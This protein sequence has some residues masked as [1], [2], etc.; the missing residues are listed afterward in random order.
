MRCGGRRDRCGDGTAGDP[1]PQPVRAN[2]FPPP[3]V[4]AARGMLSAGGV[5]LRRVM[6]RQ[7]V[8]R[9]FGPTRP[10]VLL[11]GALAGRWPVL[12]CAHSPL[13]AGGP[14]WA[15]C[16]GSCVSR[17]AGAAAVGSAGVGWDFNQRPTVE[18]C[19]PSRAAIS[20]LLSDGCERSRRASLSDPRSS[21]RLPGAGRTRPRADTGD[22]VLALADGTAAGW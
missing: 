6:H 15:S 3:P 10:L 22:S 18:G 11:I 20:R 8:V 1:H 7:Q 17:A 19:T 21:T 13:L 14:C 4:P 9:R 2:P 16:S 12:L 5:A